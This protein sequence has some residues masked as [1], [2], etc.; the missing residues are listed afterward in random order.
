MEEEG[1]GGDFSG[2]L[3]REFSVDGDAILSNRLVGVFTTSFCC[4]TEDR[5]PFHRPESASSGYGLGCFFQVSYFF[6]MI[7]INGDA[8]HPSMGLP[9][10]LNVTTAKV[11]KLEI[12]LPY[13]S[14]VQIE[15]I[16]VQ[17]DRL[18]LVLE[19][20]PDVD[21]P[22][23]S[24]R[25]SI[26]FCTYSM[27]SSTTSGK[28]SGYGFAD[29]VRYYLYTFVVPILSQICSTVLQDCR[30][31]DYKFRQ[32]IF[33]LKLVVVPVAKGGSLVSSFVF[34]F[35]ANTWLQTVW[36][37]HMAFITMRNILL[38]TTNE[39]W[40]VVNLKEA[41]FLLLWTTYFFASRTLNKLALLLGLADIASQ[42]LATNAVHYL[43]GKKFCPPIYPLG[44]RQWH[45]TV[46]VPLI[47]LHSLQ[48]KPSP[49]PP[50]FASQTVIGCQPLM[51][52][53]VS[54]PL[55]TSKLDNPGG[56]ENH[57]MQKS[58]AGARLHIEKLF[59]SESSSLKLKLLN[60]EK[61]PAC[62]SLWDGL[63]RC[64]EVKDASI[65]VA[66]ASADGNPLTVVPP[67]G[68]VVKIGLRFLE[69]SSLDIQGM[70][71]V[72]FIG[73]DMFLKVTHRT[74]GGAM[75]VSSTLCWESVQVDCVDRGKHCTQEW[76][77]VRFS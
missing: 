55:D 60:L 33:Y 25:T 66:M 31:N 73:N 35:Y 54:V 56:G 19:E 52:L 39:N 22:R 3:S 23:S 74:L 2:V 7:D 37:S 64:V 34:S 29:K 44:E 77:T 50:S 8:V 17:I 36:E 45:L 62:F 40:Q 5:L 20:N 26:C 9:P 71:L 61:D 21:S 63:W 58:F 14:N 68:G 11:G 15:P 65:E 41:R 4:Q 27:Q 53:D 32:S 38:Y 43:Y 72:Q 76:N 67:P 59:F 51:E 18:D 47:C 75:A 57:I 48:V 49:L 28:G 30:W 1:F 13:V 16:V 12:I 69:S 42:M 6:Y 24:S 46:G 10:A 70:P